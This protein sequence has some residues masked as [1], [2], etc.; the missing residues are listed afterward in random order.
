[1]PNKKSV[2]EDSTTFCNSMLAVSP[3]FVIS[4]TGTK[5]WGGLGRKRN[6][7]KTG[8]EELGDTGTGR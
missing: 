8:G 4:E 3:E 1:M 2:M 7:K 5:K 6:R